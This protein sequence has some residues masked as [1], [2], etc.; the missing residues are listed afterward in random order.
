[1][2]ILGIGGIL[3]DPACALLKG[4][5]LVSAVEQNKVAPRHA[6]GV[7]AGL[8]LDAARAAPRRSGSTHCRK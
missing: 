3:K 7:H 2:I 6:H 1:M 5:E 4:G 8:P